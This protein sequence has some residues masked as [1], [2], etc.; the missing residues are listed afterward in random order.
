MAGN[1]SDR[2]HERDSSPERTASFGDS[3][4]IKITP[5]GEKVWDEYHRHS[6]EVSGHDLPIDRDEEGYTE[7]Q[8]YD[9]ARIFGSKL[10]VG[11]GGYSS[12]DWPIEPVFKFVED[13]TQETIAPA[14]PAQ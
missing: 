10:W 13:P 6:N 2:S 11:R 1:E 7:M 14:E 12:R 8:L 5:E 3:V 4:L 9:V